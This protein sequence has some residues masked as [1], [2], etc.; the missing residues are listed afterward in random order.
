[1]GW[2]SPPGPSRCCWRNPSV[3]L[4]AASPVPPRVRTSSRERGT[5]PLIDTC[6][7]L[8]IDSIYNVSRSLSY[9]IYILAI[10][11]R[12]LSDNIDISTIIH[13][14]LGYNIHILAIIYRNLSYNIYISAIIYRNEL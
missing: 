6:P 3:S 8:Y 2:G 13:R 1:M 7:I 14:N 5:T 10:I 9:N 11:Y 12:N 4:L